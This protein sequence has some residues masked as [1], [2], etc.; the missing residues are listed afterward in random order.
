MNEKLWRKM[1]KIKM[2][3]CLHCATVPIADKE[4]VCRLKIDYFYTDK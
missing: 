2:N 4:E 3:L 1:R